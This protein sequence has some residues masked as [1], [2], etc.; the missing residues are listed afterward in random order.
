MSAA[1]DLEYCLILIEK[2]ISPNVPKP[3]ERDCLVKEL[4]LAVRHQE[5]KDLIL[6]FVDQ[7]L[8]LEEK[9]KLK[10]RFRRFDHEGRNAQE[11]LQSKA[12]SLQKA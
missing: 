3:N 6:G 10:E 8:S 4:M 5:M 1:V 9:N 11:R 2:L 7:D 12:R